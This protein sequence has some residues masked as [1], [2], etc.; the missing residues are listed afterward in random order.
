M[1]ISGSAAKLPSNTECFLTHMNGDSKHLNYGSQ[2]SQHHPAL[3]QW[4]LRQISQALVCTHTHTHTH[5]RRTCLNQILEGHTHISH[6]NTSRNVSH[7]GQ[8]T[9]MLMCA[10]L[11][12]T[13]MSA[14]AHIV[15]P[16]PSP[17]LL[18]HCCSLLSTSGITVSILFKMAPV[19]NFYSVW[20]YL[21]P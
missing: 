18:R 20:I 14:R 19:K 10:G 8:K 9:D 16:D 7:Q 21:L 6:S 3:V 2:K 1:K 13:G 5:T 15:V 11:P 17:A 12:Y 4:Q